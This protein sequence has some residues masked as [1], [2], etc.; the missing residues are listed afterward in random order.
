M[1]MQKPLELAAM[2][3]EDHTDDKYNASSMQ[4]ILDSNKTTTIKLATAIPINIL[5]FTVHEDNEL[6]YFDYDIYMYDL[7]IQESTEDNRKEY[8]KAPK[9]RMIRVEKNAKT[10]NNP[11]P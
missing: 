3:L 8:F 7:I 2:L 9:Q 11:A 5:Y 4:E 10:D 6:V 1:R